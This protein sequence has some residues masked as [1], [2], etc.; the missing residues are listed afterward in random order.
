MSPNL[1]RLPTLPMRLVQITVRTLTPET[2]HALVYL[3]R[4]DLLG[5]EVR[6]TVVAKPQLLPVADVARVTSRLSRDLF[7]SPSKLTKHQ[8]LLRRPMAV[9]S[10]L[11]EGLCDSV[12]GV[13]HRTTKIVL[14]L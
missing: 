9:F 11:L 2:T 12:E 14:K 7:N 3:P 5:S 6:A 10:H 13:K 4:S 8:K 1:D